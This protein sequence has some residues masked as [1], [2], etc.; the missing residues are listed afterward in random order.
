[1]TAVSQPAISVEISSYNRWSVLRLVL[2]RLA[3]QTLSADRFEVVVSDDGSTDGTPERIAEFAATAPFRLEL[4]RNDHAGPGMTH[5]NGILR[6]RSDIVLMIADDILPSPRLLEAHVR[7]HAAEP[8][9]AVGIVGRLEQSPMLPGTPFQRTWDRIV[10][11][12]F[13]RHRAELDYRDFFVNNLS[14]KKSFMVAKGMFHSWPPAAHED[15][16][17]G[18]RLQRNGMRL[19]YCDEALAYHHHPETIDSI[20]RRSYAQGYN[21][22]HFESAVEDAWVRARSGNFK[23][24]DSVALRRRFWVRLAARTALV[25]RATVSVILPLIRR[26]DEHTWLAPVV[27]LCTPKVSSYYFRKGIVDQR[28]G[29]PFKFA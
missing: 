20:S 4:V 14:F 29:R 15:L 28:R 27:K 23:P 6:A 7:M 22:H 2:E 11:G 8:D 12:I 24:E 17:L 21:W 26:S 25:N 9:P 18:Y 5:N 10:N 16:E 1:M 13:P 3:V 19:L